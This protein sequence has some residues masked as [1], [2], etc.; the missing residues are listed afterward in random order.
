[1]RA[2][3]FAL[4]SAFVAMLGLPAHA[5]ITRAWVSGKGVDQAS[6]GPIASPCRTLQYVHDNIIASGGEIDVLDPAGYG[7]VAI[8]KALNIVNDGVG[9]AG[10]LASANAA[11]VAINAGPNDDVVLRGLTIE[12]ANVGTNG[13]AFHSGRSLTIDRCV[14]QN[15]VSIN[16]DTNTGHGIFL[17]PAL[18]SPTFVITNTTS[19]NNALFGFVYNPPFG[20]SANGQVKLDHVRSIRNSVGIAFSNNNSTGGLTAS[21]SNVIASFN[22]TGF[23]F[24][25][26]IVAI[27]ASESN[28]NFIGLISNIASVYLDRSAIFDNS[29]GI[30]M[31]SSGAVYTFGNNLLANNTTPISGGTLTA[32]TLK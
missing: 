8:T 31:T 4:A 24:T 11:A 15:F 5:T 10:V 19:L 21:I 18:G 28:S 13:V 6:C 2:A 26:A 1:M 22:S 29:A 23:S 32:Q 25:K 12:G 3:G 7:S 17:A 14:T 27:T 9:V 16:S 30:E 20:S